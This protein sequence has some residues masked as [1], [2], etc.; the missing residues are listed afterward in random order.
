MIVVHGRFVETTIYAI[1]VFDEIWSL[2]YCFRFRA[3]E[4]QKNDVQAF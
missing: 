1:G 3:K 4:I 2:L